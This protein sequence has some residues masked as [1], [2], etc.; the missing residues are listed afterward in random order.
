MV[1]SARIVVGVCAYN[2]EKNIGRLLKN[3]ISE[4]NLPITSR[5]LVVCSG[6]TDRTPQIV[7]DFQKKDERILPIIENSRTGKASALNKIFGIA[8]KTA[9]V[10]VLV[11]A[12][13]LP[14]NGSV[15]KVVSELVKSDAGVAFAQPIPLENSTGVCYK[16]VRVIW[17]LHHI[18]S[19]FQN[20]KLSGEL[21]AIR[22]SC[23]E[24]LPKN[25]A[26]D[27]PYIEMSIRRKGYKI[28]Y[29]DKAAVT[30]R[31]PTTMLDLLKQRK[32]IWIGHMQLQSQTGFKVS[33]SNIKNVARATS[34]LKFNEIP[35][36]AL[37]GIVEAIA[38]LQAKIEIKKGR[39]PYTWEPIRSTKT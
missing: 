17:R 18:I 20:P 21:C 35:Y 25:I 5:I 27:E 29:I 4:Q 19:L 16:I 28:L 22:T 34:A 12:D 36:L 23:L 3:L 13:A 38:Y 32:R 31:C 30:I 1:S 8:R 6:C 11:N 7:K 37:G 26:T 33:T 24:D 9:D 39:I 14:N 2:E 10:L 15:G